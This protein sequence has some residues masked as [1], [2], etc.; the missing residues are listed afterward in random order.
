MREMSDHVFE[1][2]TLEFHS[3][4]KP[5]LLDMVKQRGGENAHLSH[6]VIANCRY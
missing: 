3:L 4:G 6:S 1:L 2:M 5:I